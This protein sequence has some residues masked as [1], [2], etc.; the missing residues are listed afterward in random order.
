MNCQLVAATALAGL[1]LGCTSWQV[2]GAL[3]VQLASGEA[4]QRV[5]VTRTDGT[6]LVIENALVTPAGV[7]GQWERT[8]VAVPAA[9]IRELAVRREDPS[10]T[11]AL[12]AGLVGVAGAAGSL[13][14]GGGNPS[15]ELR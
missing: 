1:L 15:G 14:F 4:G 8:S 2:P 9:Q 3:P 6:Q 13:T 7:S 5:R 11:I 12:I 10:G